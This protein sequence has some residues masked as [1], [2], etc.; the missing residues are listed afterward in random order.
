MGHGG[1]VRIR[2]EQWGMSVSI[3]DAGQELEE[4]IDTIGG[5]CNPDNNIRITDSTQ[6]KQQS[7]Q[8]PLPEEFCFCQPSQD[9][10]LTNTVVNH[11]PK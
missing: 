3:I 9:A 6:L 1:R 10:F 5:L 4:L 7:L 2:T 8:P 11:N